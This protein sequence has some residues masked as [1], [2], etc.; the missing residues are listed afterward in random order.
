MI[1]LLL[2]VVGFFFLNIFDLANIYLSSRIGLAV[3]S[4]F[5]SLLTT[6]HISLYSHKLLYHL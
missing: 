1:L 5:K 4:N 3:N 6:L 2:N